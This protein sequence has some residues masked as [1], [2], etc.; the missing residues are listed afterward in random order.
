M[1][2]VVVQMLPLVRDQVSIAAGGALRPSPP[3][4]ARR[5][6]SPLPFSCCTHHHP[7]AGGHHH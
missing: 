1:F 4:G 3:C 7:T 2:Q 5:S 6:A